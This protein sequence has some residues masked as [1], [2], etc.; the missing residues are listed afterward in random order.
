MHDIARRSRYWFDARARSCGATRAQWRVLISLARS[1]SPPT[2]S[3]LAELL[4]VERI[5]LCRMVD[6]MAEAGLIER[7]ADP[8]DRRVWRLHLTD[9]A[10]P[11]VDELGEIANEMEENMLSPLNGEQREQ[12]T[13][14]LS[15]VREHIRAAGESSDA[16][17]TAEARK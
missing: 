7:R 17:V 11:L 8:S 3:E 1:E 10:K 16:P 9:K 6:R 14:L 12:L 15:I 4:D 2:Q 5:T 13:H